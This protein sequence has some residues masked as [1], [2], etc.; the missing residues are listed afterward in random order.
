[1]GLGCL[2]NRT[3]DMRE[4][5]QRSLEPGLNLFQKQYHTQIDELIEES[6]KDM[7]QLL[8]AKVRQGIIVMTHTVFNLPAKQKH[9][10]ILGCLCF[11]S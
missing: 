10:Q 9:R 6:V 7:I 11:L 2:V 8:V 1:M 5:S 4:T 3:K